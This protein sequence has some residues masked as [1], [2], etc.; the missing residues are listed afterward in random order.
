ME[1][2]SSQEQNLQNGAYEFE[3]PNEKNE[4][5]TNQFIA[6]SDK[7]Y[8]DF[9][10]K[11][12]RSD[13]KRMLSNLNDVNQK[14]NEFINNKNYNSK[15]VRSNSINYIKRGNINRN[16]ID[17]DDDYINSNMR[18]NQYH[19]ENKNLNKQ[20]FNN[21][22][23]DINNNMRFNKNNTYNKDKE[24][25][26]NSVRNKNKNQIMKYNSFKNKI[27]NNYPKSNNVLELFNGVPNNGT[28]IRP[29]I[30]TIE[31]SIT[32]SPF[33]SDT[34]NQYNNKSNNKRAFSVDNENDI[35]D[36]FNDENTITKIMNG[37]TSL[38]NDLRDS[39]NQLKVK[40]NQLKFY[41]SEIQKRDNFIN[42]LREELRHAPKAKI[43]SEKDRNYILKKNR[44][45]IEE[46]EI[47]KIKIKNQI[48]YEKKIVK[49][50]IKSNINNNNQNDEIIKFNREIGYWKKEYDK[51]NDENLN[52]VKDIETIKK[53]NNKLINDNKILENNK[54]G[55]KKIIN[56]KNRLEKEN[57]ELKKKLNSGRSQSYTNIRNSNNNNLNKKK[58][59]ENDDLNNKI[60]D[61]IEENKKLNDLLKQN[62]LNYEKEKE[63]INI[64]NQKILIN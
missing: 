17:D 64:E 29:N 27:I 9:S 13:I 56:E 11:E 16:L 36:N 58:K 49:D 60:T 44:D 6:S 32:N 40:G 25:K 61:L 39:Q 12:L 1:N 59:S 57:K 14:T 50:K 37:Y 30:R 28:S 20:E 55:F 18:Y 52:L 62:S 5:Q 33:H 45:L 24:Y 54:K 35:S 63:K 2:Y 10:I 46:N 42:Q 15:N 22:N 41:L 48:E 26:G 34:N 21:P 51:K 53:E 19:Y 8:L 43:F 38:Q 31:K 23:M 3:I 47:L 4:Y 7:K